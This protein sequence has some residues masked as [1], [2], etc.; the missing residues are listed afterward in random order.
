[1]SC[2]RKISEEAGMKEIGG[3]LELEKFRGREY[4]PDL[5]KLNLGR[6]AAA[7]FLEAAGCRHLYLPLFMCTSVTEAVS[8]LHIRISRYRLTADF[9]PDPRDLPDRPLAHDEW[10]YLMN[11]YG[12]LEDRQL[13]QIG[14]DRG[15]VFYDFTHAFFQRPPEGMP[16]VASVRKFFGVTDGALLQSDRPLALPPEQDYSCGRFTHILGRYEKTAG[17]FYRQMLDNAHS[18]EGAPVRRMSA[19]TEN[20]LRGI[21]YEAAASARLANFKALDELLNPYNELAREGHFRTPDI[22]PF[23]YPMLVENAPEIRRKLAASMIYVPQYWSDVASDNPA[24]SV[25]QR[26]A[27]DILA[28]PCDH[29]YNPEDMEY[30]A[31][32]LLHMVKG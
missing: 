9:L 20:L 18:Y 2:G 13:I 30:L 15:Q 10:L 14:R 27:A 21:D 5:I 1:M 23:A 22:G 3:Y 29:R 31:S 26:Y 24:G 16:A 12:L 6:S 8:A 11:P 32:Q 25:E 19:L 28:L 4:Y 17:E 7:Y